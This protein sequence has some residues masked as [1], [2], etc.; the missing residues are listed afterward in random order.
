MRAGG[1]ICGPVGWACDA[2]MACCDAARRVLAEAEG[3]TPTSVLHHER[4]RSVAEVIGKVRL[5]L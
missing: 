5:V 1:S 4:C 2:S 3:P